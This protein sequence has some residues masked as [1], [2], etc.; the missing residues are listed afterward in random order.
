MGIRQSLN[1]NPVV[2]T[3]ITVVIMV[4]AIG[5]IGYKIFF[6]G[7]PSPKFPSTSYFSDDNGATWYIDDAKNIP[8]YDHNGKKAYIA[9]L[10]RC[11]ETGKPFVGYLEGFDDEAKA[12]I[13]DKM[14]K[15]GRPALAAERLYMNRGMMI[16]RP[17][18]TDW[19]ESKGD[20][21]DPD[22][23]KKWAEIMN[24]KCPGDSGMI[25][26]APNLRMVGVDENAKP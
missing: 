5:F 10:F 6:G 25:L 21:R 15:E 13:A 14:Q 24:P 17:Q 26:K 20:S 8:P 18:D 12:K 16:K 1:E 22:T 9:K 23:M 7:A 11:G 2:T 19:V 3:I 4:S